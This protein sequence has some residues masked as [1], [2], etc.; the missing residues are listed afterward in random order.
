MIG[1]ISAKILTN[2]TM[3]MILQFILDARNLSLLYMF[4]GKNQIYMISMEYNIVIKTTITPSKF[5][6]SWLMQILEKQLTKQSF[7][8]CSILLQITIPITI[9]PTT[10]ITGIRQKLSQIKEAAFGLNLQLLMDHAQ[11]RNVY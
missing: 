10:A 9:Y 4:H 3:A 2:S 8:S 11:E 5:I 1:T 6:F 7:Q